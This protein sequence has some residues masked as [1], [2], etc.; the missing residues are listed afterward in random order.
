MKVNM[1]EVVMSKII[2]IDWDEINSCNDCKETKEW[3]PEEN[4]WM[5]DTDFCDRHDPDLDPNG[6]Y[7]E[8]IQNPSNCEGGSIRW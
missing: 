1:G 5:P 8:Y 2:K 7:N 4:V 3:M 6:M